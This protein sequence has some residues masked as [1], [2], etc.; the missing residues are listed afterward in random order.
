MRSLEKIFLSVLASIAPACAGGSDPCRER[1]G[2][3]PSIETRYVPLDLACRDDRTPVAS[4]PI[5]SGSEGPAAAPTPA[6]ASAGQTPCVIDCQ[7]VCT[8][9]F[10][11]APERCEVSDDRVVSCVIAVQYPCGRLVD[12]VDPSWSRPDEPLVEMHALEAVSVVAFEQLARELQG[13]GAPAGLVRRALRAAADERRHAA[14]AE[15]LLRAR[16]LRAAA[17]AV[18]APVARSMLRVALENATE[19]CVRE[20]WGALVAVWQRAHET[21][22]QLRRFYE[23]IAD[24]EQQHA[25]FSWHLDEWLRAQL[26]PSEESQVLQARAHAI[27]T[28]LA[29]L[30]CVRRDSASSATALKL[31]GALFSE[32]GRA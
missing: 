3:P 9:F 10:H 5:P 21:S 32:I 23:A 7:S 11:Q 24:D 22:P 14:L 30:A 15:R 29:E 1:G 26:A 31:A 8:R 17:P 12:G 4:P 28:L 27:T 18:T 16:G 19:G 13:W 2:N 20:T 6:A 25:V